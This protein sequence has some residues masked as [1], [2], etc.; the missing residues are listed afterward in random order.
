VRHDKDE[1]STDDSL[2]GLGVKFVLCHLVMLLERL[3]QV[4]WPALA[5]V[6]LFVALVLLDGF[7]V[8]PVWLHM[9]LLLAF[10]L[11]FAGAAWRAVVRFRRPSFLEVRRRLEENSGQPHRPLTTLADDLMAG[12]GNRESEALWQAHLAQV[13]ARLARI[14]V[15]APRPILAQA[16]PYGVAAVAGLLL[17]VGL[18]VGGW[19]WQGRFQRSLLPQTALAESSASTLD[20][21]IDPPDYT[22]L[23]PTFLDPDKP[24]PLTV[25]SGS[26]LLAHAQSPAQPVLEIDGQSLPFETFSQDGHKIEHKIT[27]GNEISIAAGGTLLGDWPITLLADGPPEVAFADPPQR[28]ERMSL[29][30]AYDGSDDFGVTGL[31]AVVNRIDKPDL[32]PIELELLLPSG[33]PTHVEGV[34]FHDLTAHPWAGLAV[35]IRLR[36]VDALGQTSESEAARSVLPERVFNNPVAQALVA[37]RKQL[38]LEPNNRYPIVRGVRQI[39]N[40]PADYHN[41]ILV[42]LTLHSAAGRLINDKQPSA[43]PEVQDLLWN[44]ALRIE[45]GEMG[46]A[47]QDLRAAQQALLD[48]LAKG[49]SEADIEQLMDELQSA[50][51]NFL[52]SLADQLQA[53]LQRGRPQ[54]QAAPEGPTLDSQDLRE[55]I[56]KARELARSGARDAARDLLS[57]L[58]EMLENLRAQPYAQMMNENQQRANEMMRGME[59]MLDR[60][61]ELMD[62]SHR[63][64]RERNPNESQLQAQQ[65]GNQEDAMGQEQ[66]RKELGE[67]MRQ[68]SDML[69][70]MPQ[71]LGRAETEMRSAR[72][73]LQDNNAAGAVPPQGRSLDYLQ[74]GMQAMAESFMQMFDSAQGQG[75]GT[76]GSRPGQSPWGDPLGRDTGFGRKEAIEGVKIP[77]EMD[78]MRSR[79]ILQELRRRRGEFQRPPLELDYID[80]LLHQF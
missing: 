18:A 10:L 36:A 51:D 8:L 25:V 5:L 21:W 43:V 73:A 52:K 67:M 4:A 2:K 64:S 1:P 14:P 13:R 22:R 62:R 59:Q 31:I 56:E 20:A 49:A 74:Q 54:D 17:V 44:A 46:L 50:L 6:A 58:Q 35:E 48:A 19:D 7:A 29:R 77:D 47:E 75:T 40:Q 80:R 3:W 65:Q 37:L 33:D 57:Q 68:L 32:A 12:Q 76:V 16:D 23:P 61:K 53:D 60:Q 66:L 9:A 15:G 63:R 26:T 78:L 70:D 11:A 30:L 72:D 34:S 79:E 27:G 55:M 28:T 71:N 41:D 39:A 24:E 42:A 45:E 38:T 69:G